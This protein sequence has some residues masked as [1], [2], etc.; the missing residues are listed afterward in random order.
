M[1]PAP[2]DLAE[3]PATARTLRPAEVV[4]LHEDDEEVSVHP[5]VDLVQGI[6]YWSILAIGVVVPPIGALY[7]AL[8]G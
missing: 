2:S 1:Q 4:K 3:A 6:I 5:I 7:N 8:K